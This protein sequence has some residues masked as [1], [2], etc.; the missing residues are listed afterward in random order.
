[1]KAKSG[2]YINFLP[3]DR[4]VPVSHKDLTVLDVALRAGIELDHTCGGFATC[5]T[6]VVFVEQGLEALGPRDEIEAELAGDR[7]FAPEERLSCQMKPINGLI[8]RRGKT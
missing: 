5:G 6:C 1:M 2:I 3:E 4:D 7:G 8:L